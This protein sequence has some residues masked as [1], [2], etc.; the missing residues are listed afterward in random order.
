MNDWAERWVSYWT[1][2]HGTFA[3]TAEE[4]AGIMQSLTFL[5]QAGRVDTK[6]V[7][8]LRTASDYD[9]PGNNMTAGALLAKD[10]DIHGESAYLESLDSAYRVGSIIVKELATHWPRYKT[11]PPAAP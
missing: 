8:I 4:D 2:G 9:T 1:G 5:A 7:L 3:M 10:A 11:T 6:R